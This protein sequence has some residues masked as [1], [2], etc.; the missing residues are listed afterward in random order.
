MVHE[1]VHVW[2]QSSLH[3]IP[4]GLIEGIADYVR[5]LHGLAPPHWQK[6][7]SR[8]WLAGYQTTG[9]FLAWIEERYPG[10]VER[11]NAYC[12]SNGEWSED[13]IWWLVGK[14][15][16]ELWAEY[17]ASIPTPTDEAP[18]GQTIPT[19]VPTPTEAAS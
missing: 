18:K 3:N 11:L 4:G 9:Y 15:V 10:F 8:D 13:C 5:L 14:P 2:Q 17:Q 16:D 19:H 7:R 12:G 1:L 6:E